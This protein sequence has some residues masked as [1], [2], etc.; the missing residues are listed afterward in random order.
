VFF[1]NTNAFDQP[2]YGRAGNVGRNHY[3]GPNYLNFDM[4]VSK[5]MKLT[6]RF[7]LETRFEAFNVCNHPQFTN[8]GADVA[9]N[10]NL[11]G[12]PIF[13]Q[14]VSTITR[15]DGTTSAR[16]MQVAMKLTF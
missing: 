6:E 1:T 16:Q 3:Y 11:V 7:G 9:T 5:K 15:S 4:S 14:I 8:P 2:P 13:G 10:G 12:S